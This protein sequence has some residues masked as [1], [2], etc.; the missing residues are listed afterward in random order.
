LEQAQSLLLDKG[1][2]PNYLGDGDLVLFC[3]RKGSEQTK[4]I[5]KE[6]YQRLRNWSR[7]EVFLNILIYPNLTPNK[8][9]ITL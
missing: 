4:N 5:Y 7:R 3:F 1:P 9:T 8:L 6:T 2:K